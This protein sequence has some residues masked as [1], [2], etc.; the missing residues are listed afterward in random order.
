MS[1]TFPRRAA[2]L[3]AALVLGT[4]LLAAC[5]TADT[6]SQIT[7]TNWQITNLHLAPET[8]S[9]LPDLVAG[10]ASLVFG[11]RSVAGSTGCAPLQGQVTFSADGEPA[12]AADA[13][14]VSFDLME[15]EVPAEECVGQAMFTHQ[16]LSRLLDG[17]FDL[18]QLSDHELALTKVSDEVDPPV[19]RLSSDQVPE[20]PAE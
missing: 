20:L 17:E 15:V 6:S 8:P 2:G 18:A 3:L 11:Q 13:D 14:R 1:T 16:E 10:R 12:T 9:A 4:P 5:G 7:G 19:I